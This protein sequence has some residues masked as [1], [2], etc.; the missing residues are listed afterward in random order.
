MGH[1]PKGGRSYE[2][3][4]SGR[5]SSLARRRSHGDGSSLHELLKAVAPVG[6]SNSNRGEKLGLLKSGGMPHTGR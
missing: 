4:P 3:F 2:T 6:G 1:T 5:A